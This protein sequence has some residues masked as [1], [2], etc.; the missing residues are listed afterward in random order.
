MSAKAVRILVCVLALGLLGHGF[1]QEQEVAPADNAAQTFFKQEELDQMLAPIALYPDPLLAQVLM[2]ATYPLEV[3]QLARWVKQNPTLKGDQL[4]TAL[5]DQPWDPSV[6]SLAEFPQVLSAMDQDLNWTERLGEAFLAQKDQ[7]MATV[8]ELRRR[9]QAVGSLTTTPQQTVVADDQYIAIEPAAPD[10]IYVPVYDPMAVYGSWWWPA[11]PPIVFL[12]PPDAVFVS[13]FYWGIGIAF[14]VGL[15]GLCDW[16]HHDVGINVTDYNKFNRT[17]ITSPRWEHDPGHRRFIQYR[18]P[19]LRQRYGQFDRSGTEAR[20]NFRGFEGA[21]P[22]AGPAGRAYVGR[23]GTAGGRRLE[24]PP[25]ASPP[26]GQPQVRSPGGE[27]AR[28]PVAIQPRQPLE[29][30][31]PQGSVRPHVFE[32]IDRGAAVHGFSQRGRESS[33]SAATHGHPGGAAQGGSRGQ[34][35]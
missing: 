24:P 33:Q 15:W 28:P 2:A 3:V 1:A 12:P 23:P 8:Q 34:H 16:H 26:G 29:R 9:A 7:V 30:S 19:A 4:Q 18:D 20:R 5:Q 35:R 11:Y 13:G 31:V 22:G 14:G 6:K 21:A 32:G 10:I 27:V 25:P 17:R